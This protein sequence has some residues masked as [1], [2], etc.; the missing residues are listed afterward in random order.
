MVCPI[1]AGDVEKGEPYPIP[2]VNRL[3]EVSTILKSW[4]NYFR[5]S[6]KN[7]A[8]DPAFTKFNKLFPVLA[9]RMADVIDSALLDGEQISM[10]DQRRSCHS[11]GTASD[12]GTGQREASVERT[13]LTI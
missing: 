11:L 1:C 9:S 12:H 8:Y 2:S 4:A 13:E 5:H 6:H 10:A 7:R 3:E